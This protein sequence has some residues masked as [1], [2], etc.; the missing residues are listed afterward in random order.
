MVAPGRS[1]KELEGALQ[2][3][4]A[5]GLLSA[6][7]LAYRLD[8]LLGSPVIE[9]AQVIGDLPRRAAG[10]KA[11]VARAPGLFAWRRRSRRGVLLAL[12]WTGSS[13]GE[14]LIGRHPSCDVRLAESTVSRRHARLVFRDGGWIVQDLESTNGTAVN[15]V[16]VGRC[17]LR[18]GD[19]LLLGDQL[20]RVD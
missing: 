3:A 19:R 10:W 13:G 5:D 15:G 7:T 8:L 4:Y 16:K 12:D 1:R 11:L 6:K 9:P 14:L 2:A 17:R 18:P 20:L